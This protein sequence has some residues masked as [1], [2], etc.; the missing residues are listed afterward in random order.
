MNPA[1]RTFRASTTQLLEHLESRVLLHGVTVITHGFIPISDDRPEWIT[2]M[3]NAIKARTDS[4]TAI[5]T[6]RLEPLTNST[7]QVTEF[8]RLSGP[9]PDSDDSDNAETVLLLDWAA[10]S[11]VVVDNYSVDYL[12]GVVTPYFLTT[13]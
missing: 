13:F 8:S 5:Y 1:Q 7:V 9:S 12:A 3:G 11:G 6:L 10:A 4:S 2:E